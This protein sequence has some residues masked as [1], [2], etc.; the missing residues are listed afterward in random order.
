MKKTYACDRYP[1]L[2][3]GETVRF[4]NG[5][6]TTEDPA[7]QQ[8]IEARDYYGDD[9]GSGTVYPLGTAEEIEEAT[10]ERRGKS[11]T[12]VGLKGTKGES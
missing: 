7:Q 5:L 9:A 12:R 6:F 3:I 1:N 4:E 2:Q 8:L 11:R 10:A